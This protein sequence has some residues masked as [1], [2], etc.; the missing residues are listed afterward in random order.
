M[1]VSIRLARLGCTHNPFYRVVVTD[2]RCARDGKNIEV[3]G[4]YNPLAAKDDEKRMS[5]KLERVKYW[6]SVGAQ[7]SEPVESLLFRAGLQTKRKGGNYLEQPI[8]ANA[9]EADGI[10]REAVLSIGLQV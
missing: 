2:S 5:I 7:P 10:S 8:E 9:N 1:V 6:L 3:V 4:Y